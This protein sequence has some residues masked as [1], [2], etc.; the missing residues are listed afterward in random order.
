M[1]NYTISL[2]EAQDMTAKFRSER[3]SILDP[4]Y[5]DRDILPICE[6]FDRG[7]FDQLLGLANCAS[8]RIYFGM[9]V[10]SQVRAIIVAVDSNGD[11]ILPDG[12]NDALIVEEGRPCPTFCPLNLL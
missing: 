11:D 3:N 8:I 7:P 5:R 4:E 9:N 1:P 12:T 10:D 2:K 6:T